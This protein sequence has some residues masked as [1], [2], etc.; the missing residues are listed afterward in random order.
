MMRNRLLVAVFS[1][2]FNLLY[3]LMTGCLRE[4]SR[5]RKQTA[6]NSL[7]PICVQQQ[8]KH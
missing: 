7:R 8:G 6:D 4:R 1:A 2:P 3:Y 5:K